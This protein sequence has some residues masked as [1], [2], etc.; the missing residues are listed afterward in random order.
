MFGV[1]SAFVVCL[2]F[3][4]FSGKSILINVN[5]KLGGL[6]E[7]DVMVKVRAVGCCL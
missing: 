6:E 3:R 2:Q 4:F 5:D 7:A 1:R